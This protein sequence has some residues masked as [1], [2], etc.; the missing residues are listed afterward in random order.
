M[1]KTVSNGPEMKQRKSLSKMLGKL[2]ASN[3]SFRGAVKSVFETF[4]KAV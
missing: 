1:I 2:S 4:L 3:G